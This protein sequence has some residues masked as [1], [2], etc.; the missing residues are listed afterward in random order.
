[1]FVWPG[2]VCQCLRFVC[3]RD[4]CVCLAGKCLSVFEICLLEGVCLFGRE[5]FV[6]V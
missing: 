2:I 4:E 5:V 3:K 1:M 6:S